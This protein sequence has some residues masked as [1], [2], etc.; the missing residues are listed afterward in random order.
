MRFTRDFYRPSEASEA[1]V[2][3]PDYL[4]VAEVYR[5]ENASMVSGKQSMYAMVFGGKRAKPDWHFRFRSD[6]EREDRIIAWK[7]GQEARIEQAAK[8]RKARNA[9]HSLEVGDVLHGSWGYDQTNASFYQIVAVPSKCFVVARE[10]GSKLV[11]TEGSATYVVPA[12]DSFREGE[13][14]EAKRYKAGPDNSITI[15]S[16]LHPSKTSWEAEHYE[17]HWMYG[18]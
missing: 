7:E 4:P 16:F 13:R 14:G 8:N 10:I 17:T 11:R 6:K 12:K 15:E 5:Y 18:H 2:E 3:Y 9:G 1:R